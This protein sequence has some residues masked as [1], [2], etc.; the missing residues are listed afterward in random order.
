MSAIGYAPQGDY[1]KLDEQRVRSDGNIELLKQ[2]RSC[3]ETHLN[4]IKQKW[5]M[6]PNRL[7]RSHTYTAV[8]GAGS[9]SSQGK[10]TS[11]EDD[12]IMI[13]GFCD[14]PEQA[15][16]GLYDGHGGRTTVDFVVKALHLNLEQC[17]KRQPDRGASS[18][19]A[20]YE[21]AYLDTD[22]QLRRQN[23]LRSGTTSVTCVIRR[24]DNQR[25]LHCA[26]VGDSRAVLWFVL[27]C[28]E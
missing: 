26:N 22:A 21:Q 17:L 2:C 11:M 12:E 9:Y 14:D 28:I 20:A 7:N 18:F 19:A 6:L 23:I 1:L 16:F 24:Q 10:R 25:F 8:Q 27:L 3:I 5:S 13:D 4:A 15:Y